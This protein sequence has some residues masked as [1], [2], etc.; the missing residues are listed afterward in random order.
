MAVKWKEPGAVHRHVWEERLAPLVK[1]PGAWA[2]VWESTLGS[3][4][5]AAHCLRTGTY[6]APVGRWEFKVRSVR[7][8]GRAELFARF[9]GRARQRAAA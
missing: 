1:R 3:V 8:T 6:K 7:G 9:L 4:S 2:V 5:N